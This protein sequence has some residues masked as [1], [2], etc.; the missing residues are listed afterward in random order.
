[1]S[2]VRTP[3]YLKIYDIQSMLKYIFVNEKRPHFIQLRCKPNCVSLIRVTDDIKDESILNNIFKQL[4]VD[5]IVHINENIELEYLFNNILRSIDVEKIDLPII[6]RET[7]DLV[8]K[9]DVNHLFSYS[10][11]IKSRTEF[12]KSIFDSFIRPNKKTNHFLIAIDCEMLKTVDGIQV[13]RVTMID[14]SGNTLYDKY[15]QPR[16]VVLDYLEKY[17]GLNYHN[18]S[19]GITFQ[20]LQRDILEYVGTETFL[21]GHGLENDLEALQLYTENVIDTSYLFLNSEGYKIKLSQLAHKYFNQSIQ[22][23]SHSSK[24]DSICCLMLLA[25]K[26]TQIVKFHNDDTWLIDLKTEIRKDDSLN[27]L[28]KREEKRILNFIEVKQ[29]DLENFP[30]EI[31]YF[32]IFFFTMEGKS[33]V[34]FRQRI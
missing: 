11:F 32:C 30:A 3:R 17:S 18:T 2:S 31:N 21:L 14:H 27:S 15:V 28:K 19:K 34:A 25:Y 16:S 24:E 12:N 26:I 22:V 8:E 4:K 1:M 20:E 33:F 7:L 9:H 13:G 10:S 5:S 6:S 29:A 23:N